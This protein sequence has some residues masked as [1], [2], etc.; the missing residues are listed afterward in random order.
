MFPFMILIALRMAYCVDDNF[1]NANISPGRK[2]SFKTYFIVPKAK[3][4]VELDFKETS[5]W[6]SGSKKTI[7][8][9]E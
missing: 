9:S 8:L 5:F 4:P 7:V 3:K 6:G 1:I 2:V